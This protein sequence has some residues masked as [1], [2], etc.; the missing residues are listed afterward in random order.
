MRIG[1]G[2]M[3]RLIDVVLII[4]IGF[5][6]IADLNKRTSLPLPVELEAAL[7]TLQLAQRRLLITAEA[8]PAFRLELEGASGLRRPLGLVRGADTLRA[9][10]GRLK[11]EHSLAGAGIEILPDAP[12]QAAVDIVDACELFEIER[13]LRFLDDGAR[14]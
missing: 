7:D 4:L 6:A 3:T 2:A 9:A 8:G 11:E 1:R 10:V 13:E 5:L 14:P 12:L